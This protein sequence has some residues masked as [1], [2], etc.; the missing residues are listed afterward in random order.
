MKTRPFPLIALALA[1]CATASAQCHANPK[2]NKKSVPWEANAGEIVWTANQP[3]C[4]VDK[5]VP[6]VVVSVMPP[7]SVSAGVL[8]YSVDTNFTPSARNGNIQL[9]DSKIEIS[10]AAGPKPGMAFSPGR[11][12]LQFTPSAQAPKEINKTLFVGSDEPLSFSAKPAD[13]NA[14]WLSI[15]PASRGSGAQRQQ[16]FTVTVKTDKLKPGTNQANIQIEAAG[17][18]NSKELIPVIVQVA[19]GEVA[20]K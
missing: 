17:A 10:Q 1:L 11:I 14:K 4:K 20:D 9:G 13:S 2:E 7:T 6:W 19:G 8:H 18:S 15:A 12:E 3:D 5:N 16:T